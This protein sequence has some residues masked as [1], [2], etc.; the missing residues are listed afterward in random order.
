MDLTHMYTEKLMVQILERKNLN[1][2][3]QRVKQNKGA[4]G[5]DGMEVEELSA[6]FAKHGEEIRKQI[7][8]RIYQPSPV[9]R[10]EIPKSNGGK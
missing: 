7:L 2:A 5:V 6:Y 9:L 10:V 8:R 1:Q 4:S 3:I